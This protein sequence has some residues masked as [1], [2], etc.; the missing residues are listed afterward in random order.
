MLTPPR[1]S[2]QRSTN[3]MTPPSLSLRH[4][5]F[6]LSRLRRSATLSLITRWHWGAIIDY[7][8]RYGESNVIDTYTLV[9]DGELNIYL[10]DAAS[11]QLTL[12][13]LYIFSDILCHFDGPHKIL[14]PPIWWI[15]RALGLSYYT[16][17]RRYL[18]RVCALSFVPHTAEGLILG[19]SRDSPP[20]SRTVPTHTWYHI[21]SP[22][23]FH[24]YRLY[25]ASPLSPL[26]EM[27][28]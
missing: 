3:E 6:R 5:H 22:L 1:K 2:L 23:T 20:L 21:V 25:F 9:S 13:S 15:A 12:S 28:Q 26:R 8:M 7:W 4:I 24:S 19:R 17:E 27:L 11:F 18:M 14:S 16:S 10:A